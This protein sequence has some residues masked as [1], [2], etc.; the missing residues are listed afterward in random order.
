MIC[1]TFLRVMCYGLARRPPRA[2]RDPAVCWDFRQLRGHPGARQRIA[3]RL[4]SHRHHIC[5]RVYEVIRVASVL[6]TAHADDRDRDA[7]ADLRDLREGD[8]AEGRAGHPATASAR[9]LVTASLAPTEP[10]LGRAA[11][12]E[13]HAADRVD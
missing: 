8:R 4:G 7:R 11:R 1:R 5:A 10:R 12:M 6:D 2:T 3:E 9:G 13:G